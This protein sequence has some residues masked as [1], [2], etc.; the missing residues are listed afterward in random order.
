MEFQKI[1]KALPEI[2]ACFQSGL[3][4]VEGGQRKQIVAEDTRLIQGSVHLDNCSKIPNPAQFPHRWDF[5]VAYN[6]R[7]YAIEIHPANSGANI[8]EVMGKARWLIQWLNQAPSS[9]TEKEAKEKLR[10]KMRTTKLQWVASG[11]VGVDLLPNSTKAKQLTQLKIAF[12]PKEKLLIDK[13]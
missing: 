9:K 1:C 3:K 2:E 11:K 10:D 6:D 7:V 4:A 12:P 13:I 8:D 5:L